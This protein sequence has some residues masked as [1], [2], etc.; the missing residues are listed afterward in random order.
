MKIVVITNLYP[1][2]VRGGAEVVA[3]RMVSGLR[4]NLQHVV[5]ITSKPY[6]RLGD[7]SA[8]QVF[9]DDVPVYNFYPFNIYHYLEDFRFPAPL[10]AL[11]HFLD[12]FNIHSY[13]QIR[14]IL[15][16]EKPDLVITHNLI[17]LGFLTPRL[18]R[19]LKLRHWHI[20]H[21]VQLYNPSGIIMADEPEDWKQR[22]YNFLGYPRIMRWLFAPVTSVISP[23]KFLLDFYKSRGYFRQAKTLVLPNPVEV[24]SSRNESGTSDVLRL[25]YVGQIS[26]AKGVLPLIDAIDN[27]PDLPVKLTIIGTGPQAP[28]LAKRVAGNKRFEYLGWQYA[29]Q[30]KK[31]FSQS[32]ALIF[33]TLCYDNSPTVVFESL[34]HGLPVVAADSGGVN[35]IVRDGF[36]GWLFPVGDWASMTKLL[37]RLQKEPHEIRRCASCSRS[38][39]AALG[40]DAYI[41]KLMS[42]MEK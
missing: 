28:L 35:E 1:P 10:R 41:A 2:Y 32:D 8:K 26:R 38:S 23:S 19:G 5:V 7:L 13:V 6:E 31:V 20:L 30:I 9:I 37:H 36:N 42:L 27:A 18:I 11:W 29:P 16:Q 40:R 24:G 12:I 25:V 4:E 22:V 3:A 15:R 33:P 21:D 17:G 39:V 34:S 14:N